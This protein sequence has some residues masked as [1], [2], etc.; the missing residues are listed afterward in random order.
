MKSNIWQAGLI[1][2]LGC[3]AIGLA[4][5]P[6][7]NILTVDLR[8]ID[9][10]RLI[11]APGVT[12]LT[13][14]TP[15]ATV[16][17]PLT[18]VQSI[19]MKPAASNA[20][21]TLLNGDHLTGQAAFDTLAVTTLFGAQTIGLASL[22]RIDIRT[23]S[24]LPASVADGLVLCYTFDRDEQGTVTDSSPMKNNGRASGARYTPEG[25][26]G[27][28]LLFDGIDD[29]VDAGNTPSLQLTKDFTLAAWVYNEAGSNGS[30]LTR[31]TNPEQRGRAIEFYITAEGPWGGYFWSE[32]SLF[33]SGITADAS[34]K[35]GSWNHLVL[36]HDSRLPEHQ[37]RAYFNGEPARLNFVY[38]TTNSIPRVKLSPLPLLL[39]CMRPGYHL[40]KGRLD[41]VMIFN[42]SLT[43]DEVARLY[44]SAP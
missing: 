26:H 44:R 9:G 36:M 38:E 3:G 21:I 6:S 20:L 27:G 39:G 10:S 37:M 4:Q 22:D 24:P 12:S 7:S 35:P 29:F 15:Y 1:F 25:K 5:D 31:S 19:Q 23:A 8:L 30:I 32:S 33:F 11:G 41:D 34:V 14:Q 43:A 16:S 13:F 18:L 42:R 40:F 17:F 2:L 28:G